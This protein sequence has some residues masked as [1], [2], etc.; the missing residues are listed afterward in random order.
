MDIDNRH[1]EPLSILIEPVLVDLAMM[2]HIDH[3]PTLRTWLDSFSGPTESMDSIQESIERLYAQ[4]G[5]EKPQIIECRGPMQQIFFPGLVGL[6]FRTGKEY[7]SEPRFERLALDHLDVHTE[8]KKMWREAASAID[9]E[10]FTPFDD[11]I[12]E[13][14]NLRIQ[15]QLERGLRLQLAE[16]VD[17]SLSLEESENLDEVFIQRFAQPMAGLRRAVIPG[18]EETTNTW[19]SFRNRLPDKMSVQLKA[20]ESKE[21]SAFS[22]RGPDQNFWWGKWKWSWIASADCAR[23]NGC[24][25]SESVEKTLGMWVHLLTSATA[26]LFCENCC[27]VYSKP[28]E[29]HFDD[30]WRLHCQNGPAIGFR[31]HTVSFMWHGVEVDEKY[32]KNPR[33]LKMKNIM[34][35]GNIEVRRALI[36]IYGLE[37]FIRHSGAKT[38]HEDDCGVLYQKEMFGDEPLVVVKVYNST[39]EPDGSIKAYFLRVPPQ[40]RTAREAVAWSFNMNEDDYKPLQET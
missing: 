14:L 15:R 19:R 18:N 31:D 17:K 35:E 16:D 25:L 38:I 4:H 10:M 40:T 5:M 20:D 30:R 7:C 27:F 3:Q 34:E 37:D 8:W 2:N 24:N 36:D 1:L 21:R 29:L 33:S 26:Y 32:I 39:P 22:E 28:V 6:M 12:G 13:L 23:Q 11:G 9:W